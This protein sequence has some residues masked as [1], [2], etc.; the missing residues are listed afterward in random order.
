MEAKFQKGVTTDNDDAQ[1][2]ANLLAGDAILN[3]RTVASFANEDI[4]VEKYEKLLLEQHAK[5]IAQ[6]HK[7]G[8]AFG[9]SQFSQYMI[10]A[11]LFYSGAKIQQAYSEIS[12]ED[13]FIAI[14]AMMFGA[15]QAGQAQQF[16]PDV[17]KA[18][19]AAKRIFSMMDQPS[20]IDA[21][22]QD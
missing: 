7:T 2:E 1:K 6:H 14:F 19:A 22:G 3:Y 8:L 17:G 20:L 9:F 18:T 13:V 10:F 4:I 16:G 5:A 11:A 15:T 21:I 12:P